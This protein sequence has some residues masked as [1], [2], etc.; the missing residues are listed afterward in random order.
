[1]RL[2]YLHLP[3]YGVL[4]DL[5][6]RFDR[7][8]LFSQPGELHRRGDL[9][10]VVGLNGTGKSSLLRAIY[11]TFR[12]LEGINGKS[13]DPRIPFP[14][15]VTIVY[16]LPGTRIGFWRT[17]IFQHRGDSV[18]G[19]FFFAASTNNS[20]DEAEHG[21]WSG[22]IDWLTDRENEKTAAE[23]GMLIR[24]N[25]LQGNNQVAASLPN[26]MLVYTSG[27][28]AVW[29]RVREPE[30]PPED[31]S[32]TTYDLLFDERPRGWDVHRELASAEV[33]TAESARASLQ[34]FLDPN[35]AAADSKCRLLDP[36][37][38]KLA[39]TAVGL[40]VFAGEATR[41]LDA[42][43]RKAFRDEL[44]QQV[45][46]QRKGT[47]PDQKSARTLLNEV[48]WW[49]PTHLSIQYRPSNAKLNPEWHAQLLV[50]CALADEVIR[51]PLERMQLVINLGP[52]TIVV[53]DAIKTVYGKRDIPVEVD[54]VINRVDGSTSGAQAVLRT[55][56]TEEPAR[57]ETGNEPEFARWPVFDR[58]Q[59]WRQARLIEDVS[60][61]VKRVTQI[62]ASDSDLDDVVVSWEDLSDGEQ[63]LLGR[64][65]LLM[66]LSKQHGSLLLLDEPE[67]HFNDSW[68]R[69]II[70]IVDDNIL[71]TTAAHVVVATH[72]SIALTDAFASEIIRLVR[73]NGSAVFKP[74][75]VPTFGTAP[76]RVMTHVFDMPASIGSRAEQALRAYME[77]AW[78]KDDVEELEKFL[79]NIGNGWP[80]AKLQKILDELL[81]APQ[82]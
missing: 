1:M 47:R 15:P 9:H 64:M 12:W 43:E 82:D 80:M 11:E 28:L 20:L 60:L 27:S 65:A 13:I 26:P 52:R 72:T 73:K 58:L 40:S 57:Y 2:R 63:M 46:D 67:T 56:C 48:D 16:D 18:S 6:V 17:C 30:L 44:T 51:Q 35:S 25:D 32:A 29:N 77:R 21:D 70:D 75:T 53:R 69:E 61:T 33:E 55:L 24:S 4:K 22:W 19:G 68:K 34:E 3:N 59:S 31:L 7:E 23:L 42:R 5:K 39:A 71:K 10:F 37:D 62:Q 76:S 8:M 81:D 38:L 41:L 74:V 14:F 50:L 45:E 79:M 36:V 66:L 49:F 78:T 54:E